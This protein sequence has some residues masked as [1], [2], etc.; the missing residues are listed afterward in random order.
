MKQLFILLTVCSFISFIGCDSPKQT[1]SE[2]TTTE[3]VASFS[4]YG[5]EINTDN[6]APLSVLKEQIIGK[7]SIKIATT[8][9]VRE[10]CQAKGCWMSLDMNDG[11]TMRV[12]FKDYGFFVPKD[13]AG[14]T[15]IIDGYAYNEE[16]SV[17]TLRHYA[18]DA[19]KSAEEVMEITDPKQEITYIA[20]GVAIPK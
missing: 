6:S 5:D 3:E 8:G 20:S 16:T 4:F 9:V 7:D 1:E 11:S 14:Q 18:E 13:I 2:N 12:T 10:V 19:G 15:V 17:E